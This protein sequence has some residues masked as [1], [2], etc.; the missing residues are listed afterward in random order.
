MGSAGPMR[1]TSDI[2][3]P[4]T[5]GIIP[6]A[7][8]FAGRSR[9]RNRRTGSARPAI[10]RTIDSLEVEWLPPRLEHRSCRPGTPVPD[11]ANG[12]AQEQ[13]GPDRRPPFAPSADPGARAS[14]SRSCWQSTTRA[15][16]SSGSP[17]IDH[18][19]G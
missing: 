8:R 5:K 6:A 3:Y 11:A 10:R 15:D 16:T 9:I 2:T 13:H 1:V 7:V 12:G 18:R 4:T 14:G 17:V 19:A